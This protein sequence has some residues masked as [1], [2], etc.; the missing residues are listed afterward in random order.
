M[1]FICHFHF[2]RDIDKDLLEVEYDDTRKSLTKHGIAGKWLGKVHA[3]VNGELV[4]VNEALET[5]PDLINKDSYGDGWMFKIKPDDK[6]ELDTLI[7]GPED[8]E[9]YSK[10]EK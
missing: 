4:A 10:E 1:D 3:P 7:Q 2:P 9:K 5:Q 6:G 8:I